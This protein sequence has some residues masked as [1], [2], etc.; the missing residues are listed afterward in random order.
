MD[1]RLM[2]GTI[3][4]ALGFKAVRQQWQASGRG[5]HIYLSV[6][7]VGTLALGVMLLGLWLLD[8]LIG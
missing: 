5:P 6:D 1:T 4:T 8:P 7:A 3:L 2:L